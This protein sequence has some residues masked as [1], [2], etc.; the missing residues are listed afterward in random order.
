MGT[1]KSVKTTVEIDEKLFYKA[2]IEAVKRGTS[3]KDIIND[4][5]AVVLGGADVTDDTA[6]VQNIRQN[7][8][9]FF[10]QLGIK[11]VRAGMKK[12]YIKRNDMYSDI[13]ESSN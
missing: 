10:D 6:R 7:D 11:P 13:H 5:I 4:G 1:K 12:K 8:A 9:L 2:K 3:L